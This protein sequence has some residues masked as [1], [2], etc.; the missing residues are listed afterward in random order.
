MISNII[1]IETARLF[2]KPLTYY[3]LV[4]YM[5]CDNSLENELNLNPTS[6][7]ISPELKEALEQTILPNVA[8]NSKN[9]LFST[10]WTII[11][12]SEQKMAGDLCFYGEPN[13]E[14]EIEIGYGTY[15]EFENRG[16]MTE[17][18]G[19]M[20]RWA[21]TQPDVIAITA[22]TEKTNPASFRVLEKNDFVKVGETETML[23]WK[24]LLGK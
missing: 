20:I 1:M 17:A 22:S 8:D 12:K 24:R 9:Y 13:P 5:K 4:K 11:V 23:K 14:G 18:V 16:L 6:R 3:Q 15:P 21:Q 7:T 2:L 10:L 19:G